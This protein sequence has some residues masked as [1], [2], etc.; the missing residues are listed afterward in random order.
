MSRFITSMY[1]KKVLRKLGQNWSEIIHHLS[2][3]MVELPQGRMKSREGTVVDAD[4]LM[5]EM[6]ETA[7]K[8]TEALGKTEDFTNE[9]RIELLIP[10]DLGALNTL[11]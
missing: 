4:D 8:T 6:F 9:E 1:L 5:D 3:G 7:K 11:F 10:L 2:Y